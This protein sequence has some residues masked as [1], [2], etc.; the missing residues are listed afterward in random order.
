MSLV[1]TCLVV[2]F[3][4]TA[5]GGHKNHGPLRVVSLSLTA[6]VGFPGP[7]SVG[8]SIS[9][10]PTFARIARL[11]PLPL[12]SVFQ[13]NPTQSKHPL[14]VCFPMDLTIDLSNGQHAL[15]PS[16]YRPKSLRP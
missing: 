9:K 5:C 3:A 14:T 6:S 15:Y 10:G 16:C 1:L 4:L 7:P 11:V 8:I 13:V 2:V 12:P